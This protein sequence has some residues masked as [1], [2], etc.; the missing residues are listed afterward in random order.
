MK[1]RNLASTVWRAWTLLLHLAADLW[2]TSVGTINLTSLLFCILYT[3]SHLH[4]AQREGGKKKSTK[5]KT[6]WLLLYWL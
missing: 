4:K 3:D 1:E 5:I 6:L 2:R